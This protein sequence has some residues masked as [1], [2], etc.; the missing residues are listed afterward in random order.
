MLR[1]FAR[2]ALLSLGLAGLASCADLPQLPHEQCGN[3]VIERGEDCDG[4]G[5]GKNKCNTSC[6]LEC[7]PERA[8][9]AGW[10]C[11]GD[12]LCRQ[13]TG[14]FEPFGGT[15][16]L[17]AD[18]L[19]LADF[20]GD[21]RADLLASRGSSFSVAYLD[22]HGLLPGTVTVAFSPIDVFDD[23]P[24]VGHLDADRPADLAFRLGDGLG[25]RH[26][27]Q[28]RTLLPAAFS[29]SAGVGLLPGEVLFAADVDP[30]PQ[31]PGDELLALRDDGLYLMRTANAGD[32]PDKPLF[33]W[34]KGAHTF[35]AQV[36][37]GH[38]LA[39]PPVTAPPGTSAPP[40]APGA[41]VVLAFE[42]DDHVTVFE[43]LALTDP[44]DPAT[45]A[46]NY[47]GHILAP[48]VVTLPAGVTVHQV[49]FA[50]TLVNSNG[51][52]NGGDRGDL[53][54]GAS[55]GG[56]DGLY[57]AFSN[58]ASG[59]GVA[60]GFNGSL[61]Q[62]ALNIAYPFVP[63]G[64]SG[65]AELPLAVAQLNG[66]Y[67]IDLV[68]PHGIFI[69]DCAT[70]FNCF[71][72]V[73]PGDQTSGVR[74][75]YVKRATPDAPGGWTEALSSGLTLGGFGA[76]LTAS[77]QPG[78][79]FFKTSGQV[80]GFLNPFHIIT[81]APAQ[82]LRA[83][84]FDGDGIGDVLFS[85]VSARAT[86]ADPALQSLQ[87]A[88]GDARGI[89][90]V[91]IDL[92]DLGHVDRL[93]AAQLI[94][95]PFPEDSISDFVVTTATA[96]GGA[97]YDF[98]GSTDRQVEAPLYLF[99]TCAPDV[100]A[101][102]LGI[103]RHTAIGSFTKQ[104]D[105]D[106]AV[107]YRKGLAGS[108]TYALWS[109]EPGAS[110]VASDV[111]AQRVGPGALQ[112]ATDDLVMLPVDLDGDGLDEV[113]ILAR[114]SSQLSIGRVTAG[115]WAV[116]TLDLGAPYLGMTTAD[117]HAHAG[118]KSGLRDVL[119]WSE[120]GVTVLWNDGQSSLDPAG[121]STLAIASAT[122]PRPD[123]TTA[124]AG[125]PTGVAALDLDT[126]APRELLVVTATDTLVGN[127]GKGRAFAAA[128]CQT[129]SFGG[130]GDAITPGDVDGDGVDDFVVAR[131][132]GV[133]V[134]KGKPVVQ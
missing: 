80:E 66:S 75:S 110:S 100:A 46:W 1:S 49:V 98:R 111:C 39:S 74:V 10:G 96:T 67:A 23:V 30:R 76:V 133:L 105:S 128:E 85:Q 63:E 11:G 55:S 92:G 116:S 47:D 53:L 35:L 3:H 131:R 69:D 88:Y 125:A 37:V 79:T 40:A 104:P 64:E 19:A 60:R 108:Y 97:S 73:V 86:S 34:P 52:G 56:A 54:I 91:P 70:S 62:T 90:D 102:S 83:G 124:A 16:A 5:V 107:L 115:A 21:G 42:G 112:P 7:T 6:R 61:G 24:A 87:I 12:A 94:Q 93:V 14:A 103:P 38:I 50:T 95:P 89:P 114:G 33:A 72:Q 82:H 99:D 43:P 58:A 29:R 44:L 119:L 31:A 120:T 15:L 36:A 20:D 121:A 127:L 2:P 18:H 32:V 129:D 51:N 45:L 132:G 84:D 65:V 27:Q 81:Q 106:V 8:C 25:V 130:G 122:C 71:Q 59:S 101:Q 13:P 78:L 4:A 77:A 9:P 118:G 48:V 28:N 68:T 22:A 57:Y 134:F 17:S 126:D 109:I 117:L 123:H 41:H 113:L 26:G